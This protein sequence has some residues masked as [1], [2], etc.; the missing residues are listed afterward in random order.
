MTH[1]A[2]FLL[3]TAVAGYWVLERAATH[4]G[5]LKSIGQFVGGIVII[6]ALVGTVCRVWTA[7]SCWRPGSGMMRKGM[8]C[9]FTPPSSSMPPQQR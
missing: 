4:K 5:S 3:L 1:G 7:T 8:L 9:P 2:G 6:A